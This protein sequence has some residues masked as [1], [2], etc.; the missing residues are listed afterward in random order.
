MRK[1]KYFSVLCILVTLLMGCSSLKN[2]VQKTSNTI[3]D[4]KVVETNVFANL[5]SYKNIEAGYEIAYPENY[6]IQQSGGHSPLANPEYEMRLSLYSKEG[7]PGLDI[8]SINK[9]NYKDKYRN[10]ESFI[11]YKHLNLKTD[12]DFIIN[13]KS[14]KIYR[15][16]GENYFFVFFENNKNIFQLSSSTKDILK[17]IMISF[18]FN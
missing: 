13:S 14:N 8:D 7:L 5:K 3:T 10:I 9:L 1:I 16:E 2:E 6:E 12:E 18:K 4:K 15:L 17:K 11:K